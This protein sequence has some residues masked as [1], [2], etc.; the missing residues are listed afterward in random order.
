[1]QIFLCD[2]DET[3]KLSLAPNIHRNIFQIQVTSKHCLFTE[4]KQ[5]T[6]KVTQNLATKNV[7][8]KWLRPCSSDY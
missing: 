3:V 8:L 2:F 5:L 1:M 4:G 6:L 7:V